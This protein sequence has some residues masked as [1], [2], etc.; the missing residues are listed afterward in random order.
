[1][2]IINSQYTNN[3]CE[4]VWWIY[5]SYTHTPNE[6]SAPILP[7]LQKQ[8]GLFVEVSKEHIPCFEQ[9]SP[10]SSLG[11]SAPPIT[12]HNH[13]HIY[14][15]TALHTLVVILWVLYRSALTQRTSVNAFKC[16][17]IRTQIFRLNSFPGGCYRLRRCTIQVHRECTWV[18]ARAQDTV[19]IAIYQLHT[20]GTILQVCVCV[21][22]LCVCEPYHKRHKGT[23][24]VNWLQNK[25]G[26]VQIPV[27]T[28]T[29]N[30]H[31]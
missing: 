29:T 8:W 15:Y 23:T 28:A 2:K 31:T 18:I 25:T 22:V 1:M 19:F 7:V 12:Q 14:I 30:H 9:T 10:L 5:S 16:D 13:K 20:K 26:T 24:H 27:T 3:K 6:Q 4:H 17:F 11:H 21:Y